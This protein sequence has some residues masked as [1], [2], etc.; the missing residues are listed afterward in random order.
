MANIRGTNQDDTLIGTLRKDHIN[1]KKGDDII[2]GLDGNDKLMG[3]DGNDYIWGDKGNDDIDGGKGLDTA[4]YSGNFA[5]Y[6]LDLSGHHDLATTI[7]D[8]TAGRD[9]SDHLRNVEF[10]QFNDAILDVANNV[11]HYSDHARSGLELQSPGNPNPGIPWWS[12]GGISGDHFNMADIN[13]AH[14]E[15]GLGFHDRNGS[16]HGIAPAS[17]DQD[18][19]AHYTF[20][21]GVDPN[22]TNRASWNFDYVVDT[23]LD[24]STQTL[25]DYD[26]QMTVTQTQGSQV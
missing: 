25:S 15:L 13:A 6:S 17:V 11:T 12:G 4:I 19:T 2:Q 7:T 3:G 24:G 1:G 9:G 21:A 16:G 20:S 5:D 22:H 26:F 8:H 14:I 18:G 10:L 23:G